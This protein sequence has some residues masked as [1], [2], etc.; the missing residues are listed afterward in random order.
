[1]IW[2]RFFSAAQSAGLSKATIC[3]LRKIAKRMLPCGAFG[4]KLWEVPDRIK[5]KAA[6]EENINKSIRNTTRL[7]AN[8]AGWA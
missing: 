5:D 2:R 7:L 4:Q 8:T 6:F 3:V 1:M